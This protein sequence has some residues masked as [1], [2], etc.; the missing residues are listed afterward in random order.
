MWPYLIEEKIVV[1]SDRIFIESYLNPATPD[2]GFKI[3]IPKLFKDEKIYFHFLVATNPI[4]LS[5][6]DSRYMDIS[7]W[8]AVDR[9]KRFLDK[10]LNES[11]KD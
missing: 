6:E 7:T 10:Y 5:Q 4:Q 8:L 11:K 1:Q 3:N 2:F 9:S